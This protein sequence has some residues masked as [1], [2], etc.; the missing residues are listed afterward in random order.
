MPHASSNA[1]KSYIG[2]IATGPE[3]SKNLSLEEARDGMRLILEDRVDPVQAA[4]FLIALRMKRET[5]D[6]NR[7]VLETLRAAT[8]AAVADVD[9]LVDIADPYNGFER[10]LPPSPFL[11][12]VLAAC[13]MPA[14]SHG[15]AAVGPKYGVTHRQV[16]AA[17]GAQID[18]TPAQA[19]ARIADPAIGWAYV[20]QSASCPALHRLVPLRGLI[21]KRPC[22]ST[23]EKIT[24]PV[25]ARGQT[26]L[27]IGYVHK[28]YQPLLA[29][30]ARHAGY[31]SATVIRG[32]EGG[33]TP[34]LRSATLCSGY[35]S[36]G[37]DFSV[38]LEP[39]TVGITSD[40]RSV[41]LPAELA[42]KMKDPTPTTLAEL[43]QATAHAGLAAL[44][45]VEPT[46]QHN[47]R[48]LTYDSLVYAAAMILWNHGR[49]TTL[50]DAAAYVR[51]VLDSGEALA[52]FRD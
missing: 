46:A 21:V 18:L 45:S 7:G 10:H 33:I 27:V 4:I 25:R 9:D 26:H 12:A 24:G 14:V 29:T 44:H 38:T 43:A 49:F 51:K 47:A 28:A 37:T 30:L 5:D 11:P 32:I 36:D 31:A 19:A 48:G 13:G 52:R 42:Q 35:H 22:L 17:A 23:L 6:E 15:L 40:Q 41:P 1:M 20:D 50:S 8:D 3:L 39:G 16:L 34:A 2:R